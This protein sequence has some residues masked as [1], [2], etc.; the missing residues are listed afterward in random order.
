MAWNDKRTASL[1][2][3][4]AE[5]YSAAVIANELG[6][7]TKNAVIGKIHRLGLPLRGKARKHPPQQRN[8]VNVPRPKLPEERKPVTRI[9]IVESLHKAPMPLPD[10]ATDLPPLV[11]FAD[12]EAHHC[13]WIPGEPSAGCCGR[14]KVPGLPYCETHARRAYEARPISKRPTNY[15]PKIPGT[16]YAKIKRDHNFL[17][18]VAAFVEP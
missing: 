9:A 4:W 13:R 14:Q 15:T 12:L 3:L 7:V 17:E 2:T 10:P 5:G 16:V 1:K 6:H 18:A 11:A 8:R